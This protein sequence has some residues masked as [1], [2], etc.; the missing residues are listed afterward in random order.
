MIIE[1]SQRHCGV[2]VQEE[3]NDML[4]CLAEVAAQLIDKSSAVPSGQDRLLHAK[5]KLINMGL[6]VY[7]PQGGSL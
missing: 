7:K 6:H 4:A 3:L 5:Q 2:I 1:N